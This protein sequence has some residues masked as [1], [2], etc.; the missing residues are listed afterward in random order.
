MGY[1]VAAFFSIIQVI[2]L[3]G[4]WFI[5]KTVVRFFN[6]SPGTALSVLKWSLVILAVSF[7]VMSVIGSRYNTVLTRI[8]YTASAIWIGVFYFLLLA[9]VL[10]W[11]VLGAA[12][13]FSLPVS[14]KSVMLVLCV[15]ALAASIY[16]L[17]NAR[18][19]RVNNIT[20]RLPHTPESWKGKT[21]VWV[22]DVHLGQVNNIGFAKEVSDL[23]AQQRPDIV[24]IGGDLY[25]GVAADFDS[26]AK[27]FANIQSHYGTY[28]ISGNHEEFT[29]STVF[30]DAVRRAGIKVLDDKIITLDGIQ[31][32]GVD[33][34]DT[35]NSSR[36]SA[37][38]DSLR[39][40]SSLPSILLKHTPFG[41]NTASQKGISLMLSG[42]THQGQLFPLNFVTHLLYK[43]YD[44]GLRRSGDMVVY[45]SS[46]VGTWG[47]PMKVGS[48]P[49][50]VVIHFQ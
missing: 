2:L 7:P 25:D 46:G 31:I 50:I 5:Y 38:L 8:V 45:T 3:V 28:F 33:Y 29:S 21:A 30:I 23:V 18:V 48:N 24:F 34:D 27:P 12:D 32:I 10:A 37:I 16:G 44:Y 22:S 42:H 39:I 19:I 1:L 35:T 36:F 9:C 4:H 6:I 20:V 49:D 11:V 43:G 40:N 41:V 15:V 26:L 17:I 13:V 14:L 47:P